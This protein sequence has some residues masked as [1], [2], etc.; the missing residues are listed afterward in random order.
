MKKSRTKFARAINLFNLYLI[1][2]IDV[3]AIVI[4][5]II[6]T[7]LIVKTSSL[8]IASNTSI[9]TRNLI[10]G[11]LLAC[12][13]LTQFLGAPI[14]GDLSDHFGRKVILNI[15]IAATAFTFLLTAGAIL[16]SNLPLL[17]IS[18]ILGGFF[19]GNASLAQAAVSDMTP[20]ETK[21]SYMALFTVVGGLAWIIGPLLGAF[22]SNPLIIHWFNPAVP[23]WLLGFI[24][25]ISWGGILIFMPGDSKATVKEKISVLQTFKNLLSI[26]KVK[27]IVLPFLVSGLTIFGWMIWESFLSPYLMEKYNYHEYS[28]GYVFAYGSFFWLVGGIFALFWFRKNRTATLNLY[29][30]LFIPFFILALAL[31]LSEKAIWW[32]IPIP[33][34]L[35][36]ISM[37]SFTAIFS[38]LVDQN[39]QGKIFGGYVG[40]TALAAAFAPALSG[41]L[42]KY[43]IDLPFIISACVLFISYAI[44]QYWYLRNKKEILQ[45]K[46]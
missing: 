5:F 40:I 22:L 35:M 28:L 27:I 26:F 20:K 7:P 30:I 21:A 36:S 43:E 23:F 10:L 45:R 16:I 46:A 8:F 34:I 3:A 15:S 33:M 17:F 32:I 38:N 24:F 4:V 41:W 18:R 1:Y 12:Y 44:Y 11:L 42:S 31:V 2:C 37:A 9:P 6:F 39:M 25:F 29:C 13:P 19:A 14:L